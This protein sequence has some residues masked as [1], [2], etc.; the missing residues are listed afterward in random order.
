MGRR[1]RILPIFL[2]L[3]LSHGALAPDLEALSREHWAKLTRDQREAVVQW[4][5]GP[6]EMLRFI[7]RN[8]ADLRR[9]LE[10][11][12]EDA[13]FRELETL[14]AESLAEYEAKIAQKYPNDSPKQ[15]QARKEADREYWTLKKE[16]RLLHLVRNLR[17]AAMV[18]P[19][20]AIPAVYRK[21]N[22]HDGPLAAGKPVSKILATTAVATYAANHNSRTATATVKISFGKCFAVVPPDFAGDGIGTAQEW[23]D[24]YKTYRQGR[25]GFPRDVPFG[26]MF[27]PEAQRLFYET[28]EG[29]FTLAR[30]EAMDPKQIASPTFHRAKDPSYPSEY[31]IVV[32][33]GSVVTA[34]S[35]WKPGDSGDGSDRC[36]GPLSHL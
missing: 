20:G 19:D 26:S 15:L 8:Q 13:A 29:D 21:T 31:E 24:F 1:G 25:P 17:T 2:A 28:F 11:G 23:Q 35:E 16:I 7:D 6:G 12:K 18:L 5:V 3:S 32:M 9:F 33:P 22:A 10:T 36:L 27:V 14:T 34:V 4:V 30:I